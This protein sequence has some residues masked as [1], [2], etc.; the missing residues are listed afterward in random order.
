MLDLT[1][2]LPGPLATKHLAEMGAS[3]LKVEGP[4]S[5]GQE[6]GTRHMGLTRA[7]REAGRPSLTFRALNEGKQIVEID[8]R[9][10][11]GRAELLA[12]VREADLLV[13]G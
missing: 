6:D 5:D 13:E 7:D 2:L 4:A 10:E 11:A 12:Q 1:K 3:V 8:L 9:S